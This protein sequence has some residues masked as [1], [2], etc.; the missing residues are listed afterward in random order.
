MSS[1]LK[2]IAN[3]GGVIYNLNGTGTISINKNFVGLGNCD[4][5]SDLFKPVSNATRTLVADSAITSFDTSTDDMMGVIKDNTLTINY[6]PN[7]I[8]SFKSTTPGL[9]GSVSSNTLTINYVLPNNVVTTFNTTTPGLVGSINNRVLNLNYVPAIHSSGINS[10]SSDSGLVGTISKNNLRIEYSLPT[11]V[12]QRV[13]TTTPGLV[14]TVVAN[15]LN[16]NYSLPLNVVRSFKTS[17]PGLVGLIA[18]NCLTLDYN[19]LPGGG[20][21]K[22]FTSQ[23]LTWNISNDNLNIEYFLPTNIPTSLST[24]TA[25]LSGSV[26]ANVLYVDYSL[27][28]SVVK[29]FT[30]SLSGLTGTITNNNL[31]VALPATVPTSFTTTTSGL[32]GSI[33][34]NVLTLNYTLPD[35]ALPDTVPTSF[36]TTT[37][38]LTCTI[39]NKVLTINFNRPQL[40]WT[41]DATMSDSID[42][43]R[44]TY[45][46]TDVTYGDDRFAVTNGALSLLSMTANTDATMISDWALRK[47]WGMS[48][49][50]YTDTTVY[51]KVITISD[52]TNSNVRLT[53]AFNQSNGW[54]LLHNS[55]LANSPASITAGK[56]IHFTIGTTAPDT[57]SVYMNGLFILTVPDTVGGKNVDIV[58]HSVSATNVLLDD[59]KIYQFGITFNSILNDYY[60]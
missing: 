36:T 7:F 5:T 53:F 54:D 28:T 29:S 42:D 57:L 25:G 32:S 31:D 14:G 30:S 44:P 37:P 18:D 21:I 6:R 51:N 47:V 8:N 33:S 52:T 59:L 48:F 20:G 41:F 13:S 39:L 9:A 2:E 34:A 11:S 58:V 4:N 17:T 27:P 60:Y 50:V 43:T 55:S 10:F 26:S 16:I 22:T 38:G 12:V 40:Y 19:S 15:N 23:S 46:G 35:V 3:S 24:T 1:S 45:T 49:W 56:W